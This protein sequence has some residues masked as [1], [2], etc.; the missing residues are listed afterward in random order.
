M[1]KNS[2]FGNYNTNNHNHIVI[3]SD[4]EINDKVELYYHQ[5]IKYIE[6]LE[7][8]AEVDEKDYHKLIDSFLSLP[9]AEREQYIDMLSPLNPDCKKVESSLEGE[10]SNLAD[11]MVSSVYGEGRPILILGN[12]Y[13]DELPLELSSRYHSASRDILK[14]LMSS[15]MHVHLSYDD[16]AGAL[17]SKS[18]M[19]YPNCLV[20]D[21]HE[22]L[23]QL[24]KTGYPIGIIH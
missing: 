10:V 3:N 12:Y 21:S 23:K 20:V 7:K 4:N 11:C 6:K 8:F 19:I 14:K 13:Y 24:I 16:I 18:S 17:K 9:V 5:T 1:K 15:F 22:D 2:N